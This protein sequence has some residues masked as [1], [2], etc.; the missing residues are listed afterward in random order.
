LKQERRKEK[1]TA[2][3]EFCCLAREK[4]EDCL[5]NKGMRRGDSRRVTSSDHNEDPS[6]QMDE[7][8]NTILETFDHST[9]NGFADELLL[10]FAH[11]LQS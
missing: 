3:E 5:P 6:Q 2:S 4:G 9:K 1:Q 11:C 7:V 8:A 10:D